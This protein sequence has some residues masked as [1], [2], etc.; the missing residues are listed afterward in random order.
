MTDRGAG[1]GPE[2]P[3][4]EAIAREWASRILATSYVPLS[5]QEV[6]ALLRG[7]VDT[8]LAAAAGRRPQE[9]ASEAGGHLVRLHFTRSV[10]LE[11]SLELLG[12][13]LPACRSDADPGQLN[14]VLSAFAAGFAGQ[15]REVTLQQQENVKQAVMS[16]R[17]RAEEALRASE[18]RSRTVFEASAVGIAIARLDG[19]V[20]ETNPAMHRIFQAFPEELLGT[21]VVRLADGEWEQELRDGQ[22]AIAAGEK[23]FHQVD[24][25]FTGSDGE[26]VWTQLSA[27]LVR[28]QHGAPEYQVL[29]YE[30]ITHRHMLQEHFRRQATQDP[31]TGLANRTLLTNRVESALLPDPPG[32]RV[33]ICY[34]DLDGF[35]AVNDSLGHPVGDELLR[36]VAHRLQ[37]LTESDGAL[38]ARMGGDEFV[39]LVPDSKGPEPL[40]R[41]VEE[42]LAE[43]TRPV[44]VGQHELTAEASVGVVERPVARTGVEELLRDADI[45][46]YRA[47]VDGRAQWVL[48][49]SEH[50][51]AARDRFRLSA[52]LPSALDGEELYLEYLPVRAL[53][54]GRVVA[55]DTQVWWDHNEFGELH[56]DRF[57]GLAEE[58]GMITRLGNWMLERVCEHVATWTEQLGGDRCPVALVRLSERHC[59][60]ADVV[61][62]VQR[63]LT[64]SGVRPDRLAFGLPEPALFD[65]DGDPVDV[66][67]IFA[68]MGVRLV[69]HRFGEDPT[70]LRRMRQLPVHAVEIGGSYLDS[71]A[72]AAGPEVFD[73]HHLRTLTTAAGLLELPV[74]A[75]GVNTAVQAERLRAE[76]VSFAQGEH[77]GGSHSALEVS[78]ALRS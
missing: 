58:T 28:D 15:L 21:H 3:E 60:D 14:A 6:V 30:D 65:A 18:T 38:A 55:V 57:L 5:R 36:Q 23:D 17:D 9:A 56:A 42:M 70:R 40:V 39:V 71:F 7:H 25:R 20:E 45:T 37:A 74:F 72:G 34:F 12:E 68:D 26:E 8:L 4:R 61:G 67:E 53:G 47:K 31:L 16:A 2:V 73:E 64:G 41:R 78:A 50:N 48:F 27:T 59:R 35:K 43:I 29:L 10:A 76:G 24:L 52:D 49:D 46:L 51:A 19:V 54:S 63:I 1:E 33:G 44:R 69:V 32:R 75:T 22:E 13:R 77:I 66:V 62:D 11:R